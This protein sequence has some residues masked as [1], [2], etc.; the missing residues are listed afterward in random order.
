MDSFSKHNKFSKIPLENLLKYA[1]AFVSDH[2]NA[3]LLAMI[4]GIPAF[5]TNKSLNKLGNIKNIEN[6]SINYEIFNN[7]AYGQWTLEEMRSGEAWD[8]LKQNII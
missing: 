2:S 3:G 8:F 6:G 1:W 5:Y 7:L 4:S